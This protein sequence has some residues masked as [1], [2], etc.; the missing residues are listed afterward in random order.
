M[1]VSAV[2]C[3]FGAASKTP[4]LRRLVRLAPLVAELHQP[5]Q[6][7]DLVAPVERGERVVSSFRPRLP[8]L[9]AGHDTRVALHEQRLGLGVLLLAE[10]AG[11]EQHLRA[12]ED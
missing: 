1:S 5:R 9:V 6:S 11:A 7:L 4:P 2:G 3:N 8:A 12:D 10:Q